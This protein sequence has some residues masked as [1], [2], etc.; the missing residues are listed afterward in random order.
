MNTKQHHLR[1][2]F[3]FLLLQKILLS[4]SFAPGGGTGTRTIAGYPSRRAATTTATTAPRTV[5]SQEN[6]NSSVFDLIKNA[7]VIDPSSGK[8]CS[9]LEGIVPSES[10]SNDGSVV[11]AI[12]NMF[13]GKLNSGASNYDYLLVIIMP[14][15]GDFD[16]AEYAELLSAVQQDLED[17]KIALRIVG[18]GDETSAK[19]FANFSGLNLDSIR[20]DPNG[21]IHSALN[22][23]RGPNWDVPSFVPNF[24]LEW[25]ADY[26]GA[27]KSSDG[28]R[29]VKAIARSWLN[30]MAMCAGICAPD[31]L[32]EILRGYFGDKDAPERLRADDIVTVPGIS[33]GNKEEDDNE[34]FIKIKGI[35]DVKLGPLEYQSLW[36]NEK[37][38]QR[39]AELATIRL[40][41]MVEVLT[42]FGTY[43]PDQRFLDYRGASFLFG[44]EMNNQIVYE[45]VDTGVLSYS[46]TMKRPLSFLEPYIGKKALNPLELGD[47]KVA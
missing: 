2:L 43:V 33:K 16:S 25:F 30:Y 4:A 46:K 42:N 38:Y 44:G 9:A 26:C 27:K 45:H 41:F 19:T 3:L 7:Q 21:N 12:Q 34:P 29:D 5:N 13:G 8:I 32:P 1:F 18:L 37:G 39:P 10:N 36:K 15:L 6:R 14:Q 20:V 22:L 40:R 31:T 11:S 47:T 35:T 24:I 17:N 23:H 28:T